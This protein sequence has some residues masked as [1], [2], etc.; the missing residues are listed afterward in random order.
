MLRFREEGFE[1]FSIGPEQG[2]IYQSKK[3]YP[4]KAD[5]C[6]DDVKPEVAIC[7]SVMFIEFS[8]FQDIDAL[9]IPGGF[10]PDY[11]RRDKRFVDLVKNTYELGLICIC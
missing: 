5:Q 1:T 2:K 11:W 3:G 7:L 6:I 4:C 8:S 10:A 9:V